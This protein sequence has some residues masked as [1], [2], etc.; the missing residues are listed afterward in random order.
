MLISLDSQQTTRLNSHPYLFWTSSSCHRSNFQLS[1]AR[2]FH[3]KKWKSL[4]L[5]LLIENVRKPVDMLNSVKKMTLP[6]EGRST[7]FIAFNTIDLDR[8]LENF[9]KTWLYSQRIAAIVKQPQIASKL[10]QK[11]SVEMKFSYV[12]LLTSLVN[13]LK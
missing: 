11:I 3:P 13:H 9:V 1:S 8:K 4:E 5:K 12:T 6:S 7:V 10:H 2:F